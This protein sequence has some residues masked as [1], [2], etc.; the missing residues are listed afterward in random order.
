MCFAC[1]ARL[2]QPFV[3]TPISLTNAYAGFGRPTLKFMERID[4]G[5]SKGCSVSAAK[6]RHHL[7]TLYRMSTSL[8]RIEPFISRLW[9]CSQSGVQNNK[10]VLQKRKF[11]LFCPP[12]WLH[13][14]R[15][16]RGLYE[17]EEVLQTLSYL[18]LSYYSL[19]YC[20]PHN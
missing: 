13:S 15:R 9:E 6:P 7:V 4:L 5:R 16:E 17:L 20:M 11:P 3:G 14:H 2:Y 1:L 12:V 10:I 8:T 18:I 19:C